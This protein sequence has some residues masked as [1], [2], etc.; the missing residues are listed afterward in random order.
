M[1]IE[2]AA[3]VL[4]GI[5]I[6]SKV[7]EADMQVKAANARTA[8]LEMQA[9]QQTISYQQKTL[10]NYDVMQ[11]AIATQEAAMTTRGVAFNSP[12]FNALQRETLNIGAKKQR[13]LDIEDS[14]TQANIDIEKSNVKNTLFAQLFGDVSD[15]AFQAASFESKRPTKGAA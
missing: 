6:A 8:A 7:G 10:S 13:N 11:K 12:S 1:G 2:T 3:L 15:V 9:K 5:A 4:G 14:L